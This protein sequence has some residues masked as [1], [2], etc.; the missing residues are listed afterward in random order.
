MF[1]FTMLDK[2]NKVMQGQRD[3]RGRM[4]KRDIGFCHKPPE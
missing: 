3:I 1:Q 2:G 4:A